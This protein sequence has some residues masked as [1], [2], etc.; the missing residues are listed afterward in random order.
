[1][2]QDKIICKICGKECKNNFSFSYHIVHSHPE[3]TK[4][5]YYDTYIL[6]NV[7]DKKCKYC[8]NDK[9]FIDIAHGYS[10]SCGS[11]D[12]QV[13]A[14]QETNLQKY[15]VENIMQSKE[16]REKSK[17][18]CMDKYGV[19]FSSQSNE[20]REKVKQTNLKRYGFENP[21]QNK[22]IYKKQQQTI[23][24]KYGVDNVSQSA[25]IKEKKTNTCRE[26]YGTD[27]PLQAE[28][29]KEKSKKTCMD[30]F[31][32]RCHLQNDEMKEKIKNTCI[33]KYG[34]E[35]PMQDQG[36]FDKCSRSAFKW[37][38]YIMPSGKVVKI[39]GYEGI[40]LDEYFYNKGSEEDIIVHPTQDIIGKIWYYTKD[41][42]KHKYFPDFYIPK[43]NKIVEVKSTWTMKRDLEKNLLK[44]KACI[45]SCRNFEFKI[46]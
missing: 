26:H 35:N 21:L 34:V 20:M 12:C 2:V 10:Q 30:N 44:E 14:R 4:Q 29:N 43:E 42:K 3:I 13:K 24:E 27:N 22:D 38:D 28:V 32:T 36:I 40:Y 5:Q 15:G 8:S 45:L 7:S 25:E 18:T 16:M 23:R 6:Q 11:V 41:G 37:K 31:G 39:Q 1:M 33:E 46:Y 19:E 17:K 9:M